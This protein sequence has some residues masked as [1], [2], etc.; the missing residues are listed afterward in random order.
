V[1][2]DFV[3]VDDMRAAVLRRKEL[4]DEDRVSSYVVIV[5]ALH[6]GSVPSDLESLHELI[7]DDPRLIGIFVVGTNL[8]ARILVESLAKVTRAKLES[9]YSTEDALKRAHA[10]LAEFDS[11]SD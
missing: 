7:R 5:D 8:P 1:W 3:T 4:A 2:I 11:T 6:A 9:A 10:V